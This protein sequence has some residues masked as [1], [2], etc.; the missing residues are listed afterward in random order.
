MTSIATKGALFT[1]HEKPTTGDM[2]MSFVNTDHLGWM[3]CNGRSLS[4]TTYNL[5]F[6]VLGYTFGGSGATFNLPDPRGKVVGVVGSI[7]EPGNPSGANVTYTFGPGV[8]NGGTYN[9]NG[10]EVMHKLVIPEMPSHNHDD[11]SYN[12]SA[13]FGGSAP[14]NYPSGSGPSA[15]TAPGNT[16][17]SQIN[18]PYTDYAATGVTENT[19]THTYTAPSG[20]NGTS[21]YNGSGGQ[22]V[23]T[24]TAE[25]TT[26]ATAATIN[27]P[28]HRHALTDNGHYHKINSN[29]GDQYHNNMQPTLFYGNAFVYCGIPTNPGFPPSQNPAPWPPSAAFNPALI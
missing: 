8:Y 18:I 1:A 5:L 17:T 24:G 14:T 4:T 6:Q 2:K 16:T 20:S 28:T 3:L 19:H 25:A 21:I 15:T 23:V 27:D 26:G 12:N 10:G 11:G 13:G 9:N 22:S 29:G 7:T